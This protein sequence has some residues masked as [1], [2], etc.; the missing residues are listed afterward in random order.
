MDIRTGAA[1]DH[2]RVAFF[3][4]VA[5]VASRIADIG[6]TLY[7]NPTLSHEANPL[8][9]RL[10][11]G[12]S[13]LLWANAAITPL[14]VFLL[15]LSGKTPSAAAASEATTLRDFLC[16]QCYNRRLSTRELLS[17]ICL[18]IPLPQNWRQLNRMLASPFAWMLTLLGF[19][20]AFSWWSVCH[21]QW[22]S[23]SNF[24][25]QTIV[26]NYPLFEA[27]IAIVALPVFQIIHLRREFRQHLH[28]Q[29]SAANAVS[30]PDP[31]PDKTIRQT[32]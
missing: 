15:I 32:N 30:L 18:G 5:L 3:S 29:A 31:I 14:L 22:Q 21:F 19:H 6:S 7:L 12:P 16:L 23:Y 1:M 26:W 4:A 2:K 24:R 25:N 9:S 8:V 27:I 20:H 13:G 28:A 11:L 17:A 10:N